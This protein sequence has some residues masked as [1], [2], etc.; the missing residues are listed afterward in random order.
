VADV[1]PER[2]GDYI[3]EVQRGGDGKHDCHNHHRVILTISGPTA[4]GYGF[5]IIIG[6]V[7][8]LHWW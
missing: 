5:A 2:R 4:F 7:P 3:S 8:W 6:A 1:V